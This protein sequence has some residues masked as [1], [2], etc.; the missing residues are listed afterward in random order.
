MGD[1]GRWRRS[2]RNRQ[3]SAHQPHPMVHRLGTMEI[4][5]ASVAVVVAA[6]HRKPA[7]D[8]ALEG[9][10]RLKRLV[11]VWKKEFFEDGEVWGGRRWD[12]DAPRVFCFLAR[13]IPGRAASGTGRCR[14]SLE[15]LQLV[16]ILATVKDQVRSTRRSLE[17]GDFEVR[18]NGVPQQISVFERQTDQ[19]LSVA[20]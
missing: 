8:A 14:L 18:D 17:K 3:P 20:S 16:R 9:I 13:R 4:G 5:D 7:F 10:N 11:P 6:P 2:A 1:P 15:T 19:P 12:R